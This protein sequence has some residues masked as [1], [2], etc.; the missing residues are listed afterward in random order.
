M[1]PDW[2]G[3]SFDTGMDCFEHDLLGMMNGLARLGVPHVFVKY[4][5]SF[6]AVVRAKEQALERVQP[7]APMRMTTIDSAESSPQLL[8]GGEF[9]LA[10]IGPTTGI[11]E[12][13]RSSTAFVVYR[14]FLEKSGLLDGFRLPTADGPDELAQAIE[15]YDVNVVDEECLRLHE[16]LNAGPHPLVGHS[17]ARS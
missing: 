9:D 5:H 10:V 15:L 3:L 11:V 13:S 1:P 7:F 6:P 14:G 16:S 8:G 2:F 12:A 4:H 17:G